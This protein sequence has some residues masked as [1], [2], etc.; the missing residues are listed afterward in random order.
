[1]LLS[2]G[3]TNTHLTTQGIAGIG[4]K[5]WLSLRD[6]QDERLMSGKDN[7]G[8]PTKQYVIGKSFDIS[9]LRKLER[10]RVVSL[11][12]QELEKAITQAAAGAESQVIPFVFDLE[13]D[14]VGTVKAAAKRIVKAIGV[15]V[16]VGYSAAKYPNAILL[17]RGV[18]SNRG[19]RAT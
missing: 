16:N 4:T 3:V 10:P 17:S 6:N 14:K 15:P 8:M 7:R 1:M 5:N 18:L 13:K 2:S 19:R 11:R 9:E 12:D